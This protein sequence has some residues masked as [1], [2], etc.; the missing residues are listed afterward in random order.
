MKNTSRI[1]VSLFLII[2]FISCSDV[3]NTD[4]TSSDESTYSSTLSDGAFKFMNS[5]GDTYD[6]WENVKDGHYWVEYDEMIDNG[7]YVWYFINDYSEVYEPTAIAVFEVDHDHRDEV[8]ITIGLR[9]DDDTTYMSKSFETDYYGTPAGGDVPFPDNAMVLDLGEFVDYL[10]DYDLFLTAENLGTSE[11]TIESFSVELYN[12]Y[13]SDIDNTSYVQ[14]LSYTNSA[15]GSSETLEASELSTSPTMTTEY[16]T[17]TMEIETS[18]N[19]DSSWG[20]SSTTSTSTFTT[21]SGATFSTRQMTSSE[22]ASLINREDQSS[23][24]NA[25][26]NGQFGTGWLAPTTEEWEKMS[27]LTGIETTSSKSS[28]EEYD[29]SE[30]IYFPPVG[31]QGSEGSCVAFATAYYIHTYLE[32]REHG[33]DLSDIIWD[34]EETTLADGGEPASDQD[35]IF[36]PDFIYHQINY[37]GDNGSSYSCAVETIVRQGCATWEAMPYETEDSISWPD[38]AAWREAAQYRADFD[39]HYDGSS[40]YYIGFFTVDSDE[41]IEY[42]KYIISEGY[43]VC[44][45]I[46]GGSTNDYGLFDYLDTNDVVESGYT[47]T[48][49]ELNHA[50]TIVGYKEG[51]EWDSSNPED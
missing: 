34:Y 49:D 16:S 27:L 7:M 3:T 33:W 26:V 6:G 24:A 12:D 5:W 40:D 10:D 28:D 45:A 18:G 8:E 47:Y 11:G 41:D 42:L 15:E 46:D 29:L 48:S 37:G 21:S 19:I 35:L 50:Q 38:E 44:T 4:V 20:S 32:A 51:N 2:P 25:V 43:P 14:K 36:S 1:M 22:I 39:S 9:D 31:N 30:S 13:D 23:S 17:V